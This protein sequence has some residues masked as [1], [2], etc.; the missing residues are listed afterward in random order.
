MEYRLYSP[1]W[2]VLIDPTVLSSE[3]AVNIEGNCMPS[4]NITNPSQCCC[5]AVLR[6]G[7]LLLT[8]GV[9]NFGLGVAAGLT[10]KQAP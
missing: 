3:L 2:T 8:S 7:A 6:T 1:F 4:A 9:D 10:E 5:G